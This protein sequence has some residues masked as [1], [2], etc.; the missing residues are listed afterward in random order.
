MIWHAL[1]HAGWLYQHG[2]YDA[3]AHALRQ[4]LEQFRGHPG[5]LSLIH[6]VMYALNPDWG[7]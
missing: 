7:L 5:A 4:L 1:H 2:H 3:A 6:K